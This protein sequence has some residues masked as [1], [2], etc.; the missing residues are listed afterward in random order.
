[1]EFLNPNLVNVYTYN[2]ELAK[3]YAC[4]LGKGV[5]ARTG[6]EIVTLPPPRPE[7]SPVREGQLP[8]DAIYGDWDVVAW[9]AAVE[10]A[11][12]VGETRVESLEDKKVRT[13]E[14][15][16]IRK[17]EAELG[18][19]DSPLEGG[20]GSVE[21]PIDLDTMNSSSFDAMSPSLFGDTTK[22]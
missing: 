16:E 21:N 8:K 6:M 3:T 12:C 20:E 22:W 14:L 17:L 5:A 2:Q 19:K 10:C 4:G 9:N 18:R 13:A 11:R 1:V 15:E 7:L